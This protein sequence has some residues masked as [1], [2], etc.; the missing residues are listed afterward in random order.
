MPLFVRRHRV[1]RVLA[2]IGM[3]RCSTNS[4]IDH[5]TCSVMCSASWHSRLTAAALSH[6]LIAWV[7]GSTAERRIL[8]FG[9]ANSWRIR[10]FAAD[11]T[12]RSTFAVRGEI[13][14]YGARVVRQ[15][16]DPQAPL[17]QIPALFAQSKREDRAA[18]QSR[19]LRQPRR[20]REARARGAIFQTALTLFR[21]PEVAAQRPSKDAAEARGR[22]P[23]RLASLAPQGDGSY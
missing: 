14:R 19:Y 21:H 15:S 3:R 10:H 2:I 9:A 20:G 8:E 4:F 18:P 13:G 17:R 5:V 16:H 7:V 22:R 23:S 12:N 11:R 1:T 6:G